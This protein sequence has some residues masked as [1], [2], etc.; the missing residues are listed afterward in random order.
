MSLIRL[1]YL[2]REILAL[3]VTTIASLFI[4]FTNTAPEV[5]AVQA[6]L[7]G[8]TKVI[9]A[10]QRWY[11][12]ILSVR[13][14]NTT[15]QETVV[16]LTLLNAK[17]MQYRTEN[18]KL[19]E[20]LKFLP[21]SRLEL[22]PARIINQNLL[23]SV[24]TLTIDVGKNAGVVKDEGVMDVHGIIGKVISVGE[25]ASEVQLITDKNFKISVRVGK[26]RELGILS[27]DQGSMGKIDGIRKT[28]AL[29]A[30][31]IIYTSG[32]SSIYPADIPVA[33]IISTR[34]DENKAFQDIIVEL[35][36]DIHNFDFVLVIKK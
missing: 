23:A 34:Q 6:D 36:A 35:L 17:L 15:L 1:V 28:L 33:R 30:G 22:Q 2:Y 8:I 31:S 27:F 32:I 21:E 25:N 18:E 11:Q 20:M 10:P 19:R 12:N 4:F 14:E 7:A 3:V 13:E 5:R 9:F 26:S 29:E 16:Q 24:N